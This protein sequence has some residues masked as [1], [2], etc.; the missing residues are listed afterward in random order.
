M[1][2]WGA[3]GAG[4]A[5]AAFLAL[6]ALDAF[7]GQP[8]LAAIPGFVMHLLPALLVVAVVALAWRLPLAGSVVFLLLAVG[9]GVMVRWRLDWVAAI[10]GP[11]AIVALL[12]FLSWRHAEAARGR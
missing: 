5:M 2:R 10:G 12:F 9:Y 3:R 8:P 7:Q 1:L 11:L 6:F 4:L